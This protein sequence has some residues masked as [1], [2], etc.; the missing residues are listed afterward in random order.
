MKKINMG[1]LLS[2]TLVTI[3]ASG[4][5]INSVYGMMPTGKSGKSGT[6]RRA[7]M[8]ARASKVN[9]ATDVEQKRRN[10]LT[11]KVLALHGSP[12]PAPSSIVGQTITE[13]AEESKSGGASL[14]LLDTSQE[15]ATK[16]TKITKIQSLWR[17]KADRKKVKIIK[18]AKEAAARL[19]QEARERARQDQERARQEEV[20]A[21]LAQEAQ[22][23]ARQEA[24]AAQEAEDRRLAKEIPTHIANNFIA[25]SLFNSEAKLT[26]DSH[27]SEILEEIKKA[28]GD[29]E[30]KTIL[31]KATQ[32]STSDIQ[33]TPLTQAANDID[34]LINSRSGAIAAAASD[35][36]R[37]QI[38]NIWAK[39]FFGKAKQEEDTTNSIS[40][41]DSNYYGGTVGVETL[42]N[43]K[44]AI[45]LAF[46]GA[47]NKVAEKNA[48]EQKYN[49]LMG[50]VYSN[51]TFKNNIV[52]DGSV[53]FG[54][55]NFDDS[56]NDS[57]KLGFFSIKG[58]VGYDIVKDEFSIIPS[59]SIKHTNISVPEST[60]KVTTKSHNIKSTAGILGLKISKEFS[61]DSGMKLVPEISAS[62]SKDFNSKDGKNKEIIIQGLN[63][64]F[65]IESNTGDPITKNFGVGLTI[66]SNRVEIGA[67]LDALFI[68]KYQGFTGSFKL[69]VNL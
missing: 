59:I 48:Q 20:D 22:D 3:I 50:S 45:G 31:K 54:Q 5:I 30:V 42:I 63:E 27:A 46:S 15:A 56:K 38:I 60:K 11:T 41:Y 51:F 17:G 33:L 16:I 26:P 2:I 28:K 23:R 13:D 29:E 40:E 68:D 67:N 14:K 6:G 36:L 57:D 44:A 21:R 47:R 7:E 8:Y 53:H 37:S 39:A 62:L 49:I 55:S 18:L 43:D 4:S 35:D 1:K 9:A 69:R 52:L 25:K 66:K 61:T 34:I 65:K 32:Q 58:G 12:A 10:T 64:V 24:Q 19:A